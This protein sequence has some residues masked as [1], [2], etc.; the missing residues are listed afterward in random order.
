MAVIQELQELRILRI[1]QRDLAQW[2]HVT[3][4]T[5]SEWYRE[6]RP[7]PA[8]HREDL[9]RLATTARALDAAGRE[10]REA[11]Q[12]VQVRNL[13]NPGGGFTYT[14]SSTISPDLELALWEASRRG[15]NLAFEKVFFVAECRRVLSLMQAHAA[16]DPASL[17]LTPAY[18]DEVMNAA[19]GL[20]KNCR[21]LL[22]MY[23]EQPDRKAD[24]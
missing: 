5:V 1:R 13:V 12:Q 8:A 14:A 15:D 19:D 10:P 18:L 3:P 9:L 24:F 4:Q 6:K 21:R 11:L 7:V 23:L 2:L 20:L 17:R 22:A 16:T